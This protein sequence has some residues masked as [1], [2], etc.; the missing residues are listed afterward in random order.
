MKANTVSNMMKYINGMYVYLSLIIGSIL[1]DIVNLFKK[2]NT[3][4]SSKK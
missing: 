4:K 3:T 2:K 1:S